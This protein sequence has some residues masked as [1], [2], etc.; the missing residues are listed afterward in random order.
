MNLQEAKREL[1]LA[2]AAEIR[3]E[4]ETALQP[5]SYIAQLNYAEKMEEIGHRYND[6]YVLAM[7]A[8]GYMNLSP[9]DYYNVSSWLMALDSVLLVLCTS[10]I[11]GRLLCVEL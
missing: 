11:A 1:E 4:P 7:A 6:S 10:A 5:E 8:E 9:W 3:F 2:E